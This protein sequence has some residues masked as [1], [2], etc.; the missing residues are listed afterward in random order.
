[1]LCWL[2]SVWFELRTNVGSLV[3]I[4][5]FDRA[6]IVLYLVSDRSDR[7]SLPYLSLESTVVISG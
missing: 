3:Y 5:V 4:F 1:M 6:K 7:V 2:S